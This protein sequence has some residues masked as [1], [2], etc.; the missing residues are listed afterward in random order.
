MYKQYNKTCFRKT[1]QNMSLSSTIIHKKKKRKN[2]LTIPCEVAR[3]L[4]SY[5]GNTIFLHVNRADNSELKEQW[6]ALL[7][8]SKLAI[9]PSIIVCEIAQNFPSYPDTTLPQPYRQ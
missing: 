9:S 6:Q 5:P 2:V 4:L 7:I 8:A 1:F 3:N